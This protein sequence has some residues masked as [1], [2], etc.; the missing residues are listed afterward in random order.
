MLDEEVLLS[1]LNLQWSLDGAVVFNETEV[2]PAVYKTAEHTYE[3]KDKGDE[4]EEKLAEVVKEDPR[5][6]IL[7]ITKV[8]KNTY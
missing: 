8:D 4:V 1:E 5:A 6:R 3:P 7:K 2:G